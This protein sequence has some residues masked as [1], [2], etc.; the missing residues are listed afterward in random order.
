[1]IFDSEYH[2]DI[3]N[4]DILTFLFERTRFRPNDPIWLDAVNPDWHVTLSK[5]RELTHRIGQGLRDLDIGARR[6]A[7]DIVLSFIENQVMVAPT[8][9]GVLCAGGI[10]ATCPMTATTFELTRQIKLSSPKILVCSPQ[11]RKVA[12]ESIAQSG[13]SSIRLLVMMSESLDLSDASGKSI[14]SDRHL[15]WRRMTDQTELE[16]T[17]ACLVYSSGTTGVPKG[18][19][20]THFNIVSNLCQMAFHFDHF[21]LKAISEGVY[22]RMPGIMQ[23]AVVLGITVQTMMAMQC[24]MQVY[25]FQKFDFN[26][27]IECLRKYKFSAFFMVPAIWNRISNEC[28]K[29][30]LANFRFCM[31]GASPLPHALQLK[32]QKMLPE[33]VVLRVNWGMTETTTAAAQPAPTEVDTE[34]SS[35]RLLP[36][37]QA[38]V[39]DDKEQKLGVN[40]AG[41]LCVKGPNIIREY[42]KNP[43]AT[44]AAFTSDGWF[45]TGDIASFSQDGKLFI[46]GRSKELLKYK[47]HQISPTEVEAILGQCPGVADVA[48]I[49]VPDGEGNDL[50]R[51][52]IVTSASVSEKDIHEFLNPKVSVYK[53]LRAGVVFVNE[54]PRNHNA[55]IMR[56]VLKDWVEK[57]GTGSPRAK[58]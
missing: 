52:Y 8:L 28:T 49:G 48:V 36:N 4:E 29:E 16:T 51:A 58:L 34:G 41:E 33:G 24:G 30:D 11:T 9:L 39:I 43:E 40:Q 32:V 20:I 10:H 18:V 21:A 14:V 37:L 22:L 55:K 50:P 23:N 2:I 3:P 57:D 26:Y 7:E 44:K 38:V 31:S 13:L 45:R 12:E 27:L 6:G 56:S 15:Q 47:S 25:M 42:F 35:G 5:A 1:M 54:I 46:V 19:R 17:T 53:R